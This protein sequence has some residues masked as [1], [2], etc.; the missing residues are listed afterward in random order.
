MAV[1][2]FALTTLASVKLYL[3]ITNT[4]DDALLEQLIDQITDQIESLMGGRRIKTTT[5]VEEEH[6]GGEQDIF[7][8]NWPIAGSPVLTAEFQVG[9][10]DAPE[11]TAFKVNDFKVYNASGFVHFF[12]RTP[13]GETFGESQLRRKGSL[14]LRFNYTGGFDEIPND[15]VLLANQLVGK[16]FERR[17]A[18]GIKSEQVEGSKIE[19][20]TGDGDMGDLTKTQK[21]TIS[22]FKR[23]NV[24][25]NF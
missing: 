14:N 3:G 8:R 25:Q 7:L 2:A 15:I 24:G 13:G 16:A 23:H 21:D 10:E 17:N 11:F 18:Q 19:Y 20:K 4:D 12:A 9:P 1:V 22:K 5:F 6:D